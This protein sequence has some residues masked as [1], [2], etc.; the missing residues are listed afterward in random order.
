M[1]D[2]ERDM[3]R[4]IKRQLKRHM[5]GAASVPE[6]WTP[7]LQAESDA[8]GQADSERHT[9]E[10]IVELNSEELTA[11]NS[12]MRSAIPDTFLRL[13]SQGVILDYKPGQTQTAYLTSVESVIGNPLSVFLPESVSD[14]F[15][16]AVHKIVVEKASEVSIFHELVD[17]AGERFY[18]VR[19]LPLLETQAVAIVRDITERRQA[20]EAL[21]RSQIKLREKT[22]RLATTLA[23]LKE[24]QAHLV[25]SEKMSGLGQLVAG[26]AH[27][28][29]NPVNFVSGNIDHVQNY[30][31]ELVDLV[32]LYAD[33]YPDPVED[34][35]KRIEDID[36]DF[37]LEDLE[38]IQSSMRL[39]VDR[40]REIVLSL[41]VFSRLDEAEMKEVNIH[42]GIES[43]LLILNHRF[44]QTDQ[45]SRVELQRDYG[46]LPLVSCYPGQLNQVYMNILIIALDAVEE[47]RQLPIDTLPTISITTKQQS[48]NYVSIRI[49][50]NGPNIPYNIR[51]KLFDPFFT[52]KPVGS[53]TGLGL[54]ISYQIVVDRHGGRM[55][56]YS[57][58][59]QNTEFCMEIPV[60]QID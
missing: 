58:P 17:E 13:D 40:I 34:I 52:T 36:L 2:E 38:K 18:E 49:A 46:N 37:L 16:R 31:S 57:L 47:M 54:S 50:N 60:Q 29:N 51:D 32:D 15:K 21:M 11:L 28:I 39:G 27:E 55:R 10:R 42:E 24:A 4:L 3:H 1:G 56:C 7:I 48:K 59:G 35:K 33:C 14:K 25:Q 22:H 41:R 6:S 12:Q 9:L 45:L 19:L 5:G 20:E 30:I 8:K 23:D 53:A 44:H 26:I 43:T